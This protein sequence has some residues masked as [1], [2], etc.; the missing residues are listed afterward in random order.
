MGT[1]DEAVDTVLM[2]AGKDGIIDPV[3]QRAIQ[4]MMAGLQA[5]AA[6]KAAMGA[7]Q[8]GA[9]MDDT[10]TEDYGAAEGTEMANNFSPP[11][12]VQYAGAGY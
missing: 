5:I 11:A 7:V 12:G 4:R 3:E 2:T 8:P 10:Q 1:L 6:N 9:E